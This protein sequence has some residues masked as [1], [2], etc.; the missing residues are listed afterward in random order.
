MSFNL[1]MLDN[2]FDVYDHV[3][4]VLI[5]ISMLNNFTFGGEAITTRKAYEVGEGLMIKTSTDPH[6]S[7]E[8]VYKMKVTFALYMHV[9]SYLKFKKSLGLYHM[10]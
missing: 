6:L 7:M 10:N 9:N 3:S 5:D 8:C 2:L 1:D 4:V